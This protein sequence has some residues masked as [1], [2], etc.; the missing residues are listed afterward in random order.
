MTTKSRSTLKVPYDLRPAK[1]V[2]RRMLVDALQRL[3]HIGFPVRDYHYTGFGS[4][5]FVDFI[6]LHKLLGISNLMT[7][8]HDKSL[9]DRVK[10]NLPF[11]CIQVAMKSVQDIIPSLSRDYK[12]ILWLDYD[13]PITSDILSDVYLA[14]GQLSMGSI[15][16]VT[17]D[18]EPIGKG[19]DDQIERNKSYF[20][21]EAEKFIGVRTI[22]DFTN[23]NLPSLSMEIL[24]DTIN[25]G[26]SGRTGID[27]LP[28]FYF[29]Y[30]DG[31]RMLTIGGMLGS[32][33]ERRKFKSMDCDDAFYI[34]TDF[35]SGPYEI[36]IPNITR[37]ERHVLDS[38]MPCQPNWQPSEFALPPEW[39][40]TY[41]EIYR[42]LPAYAEL[43]L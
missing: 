8:E 43:L 23:S 36:R 11:D 4:V 19:S 9:E 1:Q 39:V 18:V 30:A 12:H 7:V 3:A 25:E 13:C 20:E 22:S 17:V 27:F 10:F 34:R 6:L 16:L 37:K 15:L 26:I 21:M 2:E 28:L 32:S 24:R 40:E 14:S 33:T 35:S 41:R 5:F 31:H 38:A 29:L 42:F